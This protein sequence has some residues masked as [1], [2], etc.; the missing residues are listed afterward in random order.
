MFL[1][2]YYDLYLKGKKTRLREK[3]T[4]CLC[5]FSVFIY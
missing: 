1:E 5:M 3:E 2:T 4:E